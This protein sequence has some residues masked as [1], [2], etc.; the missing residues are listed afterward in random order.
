MMPS[1][2][3]AVVLA[4]GRGTRLAPFTTVLPK[5]LLPIGNR[6]ILEVVV[7][8]LAA[9][10][11]TDQTFAVGYLAH[12][13]EAVFKDGSEYGVDIEYHHEMDPRGT[14]GVL[15]DLGDLDEPFLMMN[16]DVLTTLDY[17]ELY[18]AHCEAGNLLTIATHERSVRSDYGV[19]QLDGQ[20]AST[21]R[22]TGWDEKPEHNYH[23]SMGVYIVDP[24]VSEYIP[25]DER[26]DLPDVAIQLLQDGR[27]V[28]SYAY[29]GLWLDIG[30][31]DD[32]ALATEEYEKLISGPLADV[33]T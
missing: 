21:R 14:A 25:H 15:G 24:A 33:V 1:S 11:F 12:L 19:L 3:R 9:A 7:E 31:H 18:R 28:G 2:N 29:D 10:G 6:A 32:Y 4:G 30:R 13:I 22:V 20:N 8:Q 5:P 16:G 23:V 17:R 27:Q 26:I